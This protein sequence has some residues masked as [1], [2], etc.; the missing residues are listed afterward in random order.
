MLLSM[1]TLTQIAVYG[2][3]VSSAGFNRR[4]VNVFT[5]DDYG[6]P[7]YALFTKAAV[8][9]TFRN[10]VWSVVRQALHV[11]YVG[12]DIYVWYASV[13]GDV[14]QA[15][16]VVPQSGIRTGGRLPVSSAVYVALYSGLRGKWYNGTKRFAGIASGDAP[17]DEL[18][19]TAEGLFQGAANKCAVT[20]SNGVGIN[21]TT[22]HPVVWSRK[23]STAPPDLNP[24]VGADI[25]SADA[26][27]TLS[28]WRHRR[29]PTQR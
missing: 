4:V 21:L 9:T 17:G 6:A 25:I 24:Q 20:F 5:Y 29:E 11:D 27:K 26:Y 8:A 19:P 23:L 22:H 1:T 14:F 16:G 13:T 3:I 15:T 2:H 12:D 28:T 10:V 18:T 7:N